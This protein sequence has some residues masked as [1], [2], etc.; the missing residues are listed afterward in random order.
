MSKRKKLLQT[1]GLL[2]VAL[3]VCWIFR[4]WGRASECAPHQADG[5][6]GLALAMGD[7]FGIVAAVVIFVGGM[8]GLL[9]KWSKDSN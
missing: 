7:L 5:Q 4:V 3:F 6:C 9:I 2:A 8:I 1:L